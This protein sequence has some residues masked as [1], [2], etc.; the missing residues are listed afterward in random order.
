MWL[1]KILIIVVVVVVVVAVV[2][3]AAAAAVVVVVLP[4]IGINWPFVRHGKAPLIQPFLATRSAATSQVRN[5]TTLY[6]VLGEELASGLRSLSRADDRMFFLAKVDIEIVSFPI[7]KGDFPYL[8]K[9]L[10]EA[11]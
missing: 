11:K 9:S 7:K 6:S 10:P 3:V 1:A 8:C 2:V 4:G 5:V